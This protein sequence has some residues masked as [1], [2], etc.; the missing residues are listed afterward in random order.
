MTKTKTAVENEKELRPVLEFDAASLRATDQRYQS[1]QKVQLKLRESELALV[2]NP[3]TRS[4]QLLGAAALGLV[5]PSHGQVLFEQKD[6]QDLPY[7]AQLKKR[8]RIG[9]VFGVGGWIDNLT[10]LDNITLSQRHHSTDSEAS[11]T[12]LAAAAAKRFGLSSIPDA[13]P[14]RISPLELRKYQWVRAMF[15]KPRLLILEKPLD[16]VPPAEHQSFMDAEADYRQ[17]GGATLWITDERDIW[18]RDFQ[19]AVQRF[20]IAHGK[21]ESVKGPIP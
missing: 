9:R 21:L 19:G 13:R 1:I 8:K 11:I 10:V 20:R 5:A 2:L 16:G 4:Q 18:S 12:E 3:P 14:V 17:Q 7:E 15:S 6:W